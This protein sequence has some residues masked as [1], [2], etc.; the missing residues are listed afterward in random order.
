[1][2]TDREGTAAIAG[3]GGKLKIQSAQQEVPTM[4]TLVEPAKQ[5]ERSISVQSVV[6]GFTSLAVAFVLLVAAITHLGNPYQFLASIRQ[7]QLL[8]E[9]AA[10]AAAV[11]LPFLHVTLALSLIARYAQV[12]AFRIGTYLFAIYTVAQISA[13]VRGLKV[14]CGCFGPSE[15]LIG[16]KSIALATGMCLACGL[17]WWLSRSIRPEPGRFDQPDPLGAG[18]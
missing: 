9:R 14:G 12:A 18:S 11:V 15:D 16:P 5:T 3:A 6:C 7:Y 1:V 2:G 4:L 10:E 8:P 13:L 17:G